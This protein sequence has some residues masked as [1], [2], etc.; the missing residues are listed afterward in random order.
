MNEQCAMNIHINKNKLE[1]RIYI[2]FPQAMPV[3]AVLLFFRFLLILRKHGLFNAN[4]NEHTHLHFVSIFRFF[5]L[6][7]I[8]KMG[9]MC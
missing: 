3:V 7:I 6:D 8:P 1:F 9:R 5:P 2:S 4:P